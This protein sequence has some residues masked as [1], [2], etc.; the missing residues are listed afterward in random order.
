MCEFHNLVS[1]D[2][3]AGSNVPKWSDKIQPSIFVPLE[4]KK[5]TYKLN[6]SCWLRQSCWTM[7]HPLRPQKKKWSSGDRWWGLFQKGNLFFLRSV[8]LVWGEGWLTGSTQISYMQTYNQGVLEKDRF[9]RRSEGAL[10]SR[11]QVSELVASHRVE[12]GIWITFPSFTPALPPCDRKEANPC[13]SGGI[14]CVWCWGDGSALDRTLEWF[15]GIYCR[16]KRKDNLWSHTGI[17]KNNKW[18][19]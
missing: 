14:K 13:G 8:G 10:L 17:K 5:K 19:L 7:P 11:H 9:W 6:L 16:W 3:T 15:V 18:A 2:L 1:S 12:I 4:E